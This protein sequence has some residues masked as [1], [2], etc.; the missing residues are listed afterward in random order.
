MPRSTA[1]RRHLD[2]GM[3]RAKHIEMR[4][5][6]RRVAIPSVPLIDEQIVVRILRIAYNYT[7]W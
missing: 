4:Q 3:S 7:A 6:P 5:F 1:M 2:G